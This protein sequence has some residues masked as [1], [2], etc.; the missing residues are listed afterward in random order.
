[1]PNRNSYFPARIGRQV[2]W[3]K[4]YRTKIG[5]YQ[6]P[7]GYSAPEIAA[8]QLDAD[9]CVFY[10]EYW[11]PGVQQFAEGATGQVHLVLYGAGTTAAA[12]PVYT[13]NPP[14]GT[15]A[16]GQVVPPTAV[17]PGALK[18]IFAFIK[19]L[20][21][22]AFYTE[23]AGDD[24]GIIGDD[25]GV[26]DR[27]TAKPAI[28]ATRRGDEVRIVWT[29]GDFDGVEIWVDRGEGAFAKLA[30]DMKPDYFDTEPLPATAKTWRY[31]ARYI[32]DDAPVGAF[33][34]V[35]EFLAKG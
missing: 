31:K 8:T 18:R 16:P 27:D 12:V 32:L 2:L 23:A 15:P 26:V 11:Q 20:K 34:D 35:V 3:L 10:L 22:R 13:L 14:T 19:N 9:N 4:N 7:G 5:N 21:T 29:K 24:L 30:V 6:T 17:L 28:K 33:S 1:M 25:G